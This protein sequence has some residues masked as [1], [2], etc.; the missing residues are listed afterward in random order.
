MEFELIFSHVDEDDDRLSIRKCQDYL[1]FRSEGD[2][3]EE[4]EVRARHDRVAG[5]HAALGEWLELKDP[6]QSSVVEGS[7]IDQLIV[8]RVRDE[9][10]RVLPLHQALGSGYEEP[11]YEDARS[12]PKPLCGVC[13]MPWSDGHGQPGDP[14]ASLANQTT[15]M[16]NRLLS[17]LTRMADVAKRSAQTIQESSRAWGTDGTSPNGPVPQCQARGCGHEYAQHIEYADSRPGYKQCTECPCV[18]YRS[19][20]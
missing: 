6:L 17:E 11:K 15:V 3:G 19:Q 8:R 4:V 10:A 5:L 13:R 1:I 16:A 7:L 9:V 20:A 14:C 2:S 18:R 12:H